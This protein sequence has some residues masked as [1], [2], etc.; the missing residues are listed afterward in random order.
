MNTAIYVKV[1]KNKKVPFEKDW[2]NNPVSKTDIQSWIKSGGNRGILYSKITGL[3]CIDIDNPDKFPLPSLIQNPVPPSV[4][5]GKK[6]IWVKG[7]KP[8]KMSAKLLM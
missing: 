4:V 2:Q 1:L 6:R 8:Q 7:G 5:D 3:C